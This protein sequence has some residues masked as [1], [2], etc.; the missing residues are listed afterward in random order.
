MHST[1]PLIPSWIPAV[2]PFLGKA[3]TSPNSTTIIFCSNISKLP[4]AAQTAKAF[5]NVQPFYYDQKYQEVLTKLT[6][7]K[8]NN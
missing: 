8:V 7:E 1:N 6:G 2:N 4:V 5:G 3:E